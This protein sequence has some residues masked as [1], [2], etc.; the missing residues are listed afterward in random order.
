[1]PSFIRLVVTSPKFSCSEHRGVKCQA[2]IRDPV[3]TY[4]V[5]C[6]VIRDSI[7]AKIGPIRTTIAGRQRAYSSQTVTSTL[8]RQS[9]GCANP[10]EPAVWDKINITL[11]ENTRPGTVTRCFS[12]ISRAFD[13]TC[14][15]ANDGP[16]YSPLWY[17][18]AKLADFCWLLSRHEYT[19]WNMAGQNRTLV[20]LGCEL[21][22]LA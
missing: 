12:G 3:I 18:C 8:I 11:S 4:R 17:I 1:M 13:F 19:A 20:C 14:K 2:E 5:N 10:S 9:S 15:S 16:S 21:C 7:F 6:T 22:I